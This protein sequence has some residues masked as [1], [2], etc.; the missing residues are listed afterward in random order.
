MGKEETAIDKIYKIEEDIGYIKQYLQ[1]LDNN[2]KLL[3]NK[4]SKIANLLENQPIPKSAQR[5]T[6]TPGTPPPPVERRES[7]GLTLGKIKTFGVICNSAKQPIPNV[8]VQVYN[9][10][11]EIIKRRKTDNN[12]YWEVRLPPGKYGV[13]YNQEGFKPINMVILLDKT[14]NSFEVK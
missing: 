7:E 9:E 11:N 6:A 8:D 3:N 10:N 13:E 12:G 1:L 5:I 4:L 14:M 2:L